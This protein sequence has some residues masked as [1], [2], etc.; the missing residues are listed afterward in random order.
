MYACMHVCMYVCMYVYMYVCMYVCMHA[1]GSGS[2][3]LCS[4]MLP[5]THHIRV[6][7]YIYICTYTIMCVYIYIYMYV[8]TCYVES[9]GRETHTKQAA[10]PPSQPSDNTEGKLQRPDL[11]AAS[12]FKMVCY[13]NL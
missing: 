12:D 2:R 11:E 6:C 1:Q 7:V 10:G 5:K 9:P 3:L 8:C 4:H 13:S